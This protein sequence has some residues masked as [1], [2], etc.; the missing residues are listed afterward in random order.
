MKLPLGDK[1]SVKINI[2]IACFA[3]VVLIGFILLIQFVTDKCFIVALWEIGWGGYWFLFIIFIVYPIGILEFM[4]FF[5]HITIGEQGVKQCLGK[6]TLR[7]YSWDDIKRLEIWV[8]GAG[9]LANPYIIFS[10]TEK[11]NFF[12]SHNIN[13]AYIRK[14]IVCLYKEGALELLQKYAKCP[15]YGIEKL[16][17]DS[18]EDEG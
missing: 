1:S 4:L 15:I 14:H 6:L 11:P 10:K 16:A 13:L 7:N 3:I 12:L 18:V 2:F 5:S 8:Y 9:K 17:Q